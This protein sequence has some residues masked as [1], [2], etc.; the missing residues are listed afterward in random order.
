VAWEE[1]QK[2]I[3]LF[4]E[5]DLPTKEKE[6]TM[7]QHGQ[8]T[9]L[10]KRCGISLQYLSDILYGRKRALPELA[11]SIERSAVRMGIELS[12]LDV[13]YPNESR[14]PLILVKK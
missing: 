11:E 2:S 8:K 14:N 10:A 4:T 7:W 3:R 12:R 9:E 5:P 13:M 1:I 6:R